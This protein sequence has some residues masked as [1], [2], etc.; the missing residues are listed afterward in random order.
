MTID[1]LSREFRGTGRMEG[2]AF[3]A[4]AAAEGESG[5]LKAQRSRVGTCAV[6]V[7]FMS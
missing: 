2:L 7:A 1:R 4:K 6:S 5:K 3:C